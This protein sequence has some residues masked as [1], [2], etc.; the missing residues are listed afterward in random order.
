MESIILFFGKSS[1]LLLAFYLVYQFLLKNETFIKLN[2]W[3]LFGGLILSI[4]LPMFYFTKEVWVAPVYNDMISS[5]VALPSDYQ[6]AIVLDSPERNENYNIYNILFK[7]YLVITALLLS[8]KIFQVLRMWSFLNKNKIFSVDRVHY[9]DQEEIKEPFSFFNYI[10]YNSSLY[11]DEELQIIKQHEYAH[12]VQRHSIDVLFM[13]LYMAFFWFSP[14]AWMYRKALKQN[15]EYLADAVAIEQIENKMLYQ[16]TLL[17]FSLPF[18]MP[19]LV[20][21]FNQPLIKNRIQMLNKNKS[22]SSNYFKLLVMIPLIVGFILLFQT[23]TIARSQKVSS[24]PEIM[25]KDT[26]ISNKSSSGSFKFKISP[27]KIEGAKISTPSD[28][29]LHIKSSENR[30]I[31]EML[32]EKQVLFIDGKQVGL[33]EPIVLPQEFEL[34]LH[35]NNKFSKQN[36]V[37][38]DHTAI[39][40]TTKNNRVMTESKDKKITVN[41][42]KGEAS[43]NIERKIDTTEIASLTDRLQSMTGMSMEEI[44]Q[45]SQSFKEQML[46]RF[47]DMDFENIESIIE[48]AQAKFDSMDWETDFTS[49]FNKSDLTNEVESGV[50]ILIYKNTSDEEIGKLISEIAKQGIDIGISEVK[51]NKEGEIYQMRI[52]LSEKQEEEG[53]YF[54]SSTSSMVSRSQNNPIDQIRIGKINGKLSVITQ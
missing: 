30:L 8:Y 54:S 7:L 52:E 43:R 28:L 46:S 37:K 49:S 25:E 19:Q 48:R 23:K 3:F 35:Q 1:S 14:F 18:H 38:G 53:A 42:Q 36:H 44:K 11:S 17:K 15:L 50:E 21:S 51:R 22:K 26:L 27:Y 13:E 40:I 2:R 24:Y 34:V 47:A 10:A 4:I 33:S 6:E 45:R 16:Y 20:N 41:K 12:V 31:Q 39:E 32:G 29:I 5:G 9:I